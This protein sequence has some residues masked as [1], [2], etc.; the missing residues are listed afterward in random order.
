LQPYPPLL[1]YSYASVASS[2]RSSFLRGGGGGL[3][4][5][6]RSLS[7]SSPAP[8]NVWVGA[9]SMS[10]WKISGLNNIYLKTFFQQDKSIGNYVKNP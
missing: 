10:T 9:L 1:L 2:P 4:C 5:V 3:F 6:V 8:G 7:V